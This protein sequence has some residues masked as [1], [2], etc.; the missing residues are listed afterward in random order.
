V[1][2]PGDFDAALALAE[3]E[4]VVVGGNLEVRGEWLRRVAAAGLPAI[5]L[6]PPGD[7]AEAYYQV[8]LSREETGA[9]VIPDLP[10][11]LHPA[12]P[13]LQRAVQGQELG[14]FR[15]LRIEWTGTSG[16]ETGAGDL[17]RH[18]LPRLVD[19]VRALIGEV[20]ALTAAGDPPG[21]RPTEGLVVHLRGP[22]ARRAEV[23]IEDGP[24]APFRL[25]VTGAEGSLTLESDPTF[26]GPACLIRRSSR[27]VEGRTGLEPWD[28]HAAILTVLNEAVA[29]RDP[30]VHPNLLDGT[31]AMELSEATVR[32]LRRGRTVDLHYEEISEAGTFKGVM[33]SIGCVLF[34]AALVV[35]PLALIGPPLGFP[36]T[37]YLAYAIP[38]ILILFILLQLLRFAVRGP[39]RE[40]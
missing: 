18:V 37:I 25:V 8:A 3:V 35:L 12:F 15:G 2:R 29:R 23:R 36:G 11:R 26:R 16:P 17:A 19:G 33:T 39:G 4:A 32:S 1:P 31:R 5:C 22:S 27:D 20:E 24:D 30:D 13:L 28:P 7:D 6:H 38:P 9:I 21:P 40:E 34:L 10:L 14:A